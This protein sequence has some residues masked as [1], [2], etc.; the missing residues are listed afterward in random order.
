MEKDPKSPRQKE[1]LAILRTISHGYPRGHKQKQIERKLPKL[2]Q[3]AGLMDVIQRYHILMK[4]IIEEE[5]KKPKIMLPGLYREYPNKDDSAFFYPPNNYRPTPILRLKDLNLSKEQ[6]KQFDEDARDSAGSYI[7]GLI[8]INDGIAGFI[9]MQHQT[10][11][12]IPEAVIGLFVFAAEQIIEQETE[13]KDQEQLTYELKRIVAYEIDENEEEDQSENEIQSKYFT[14]GND[15]LSKN[16]SGTQLQATVNGEANPEINIAKISANTQPHNV[17]GSEGLKG[18]GCGMHLQEAT[19]ENR[20]PNHQ[21]IDNTGNE[22]NN[23]QVNENRTGDNNKTTQDPTM[24]A[25][26]N[27]KLNS[28]TMQILNLKRKDS[29]TQ[30]IQNKNQQI[31]IFHNQKASYSQSLYLTNQTKLKEKLQ[32]LNRRYNKLTN[33]KLEAEQ[34]CKNP[35]PISP[36]GVPKLEPISTLLTTSHPSRSGE[37]R[38]M[39]LQLLQTSPQSTPK[40]T[41]PVQDPR[42]RNKDSTQTTKQKQSP[43]PRLTSRISWTEDEREE[44][45]REGRDLENCET[46]KENREILDGNGD[47]IQQRFNLQ[48]KDNQR[49]NKLQRWLW[50]MK[51]RGTKEEAQEYKIIIEEQ[52][53]ENILIP[54]GKGQIKWYNP[55]FMIKKANGKL[56]KILNVK[57]SNEQVADFHF[58]MHDLNEVKQTIRLGDSGTSLDHS[59]AVRR[60]IVQKESQPYLAIEFQNYYYT[61]R[62]MLFGT[63]HSPIYFATAMELIIRE[64]RMKTEIRIINSVDDILLLLQN[65]KYLKNKT[66]QVI[67]TLKYFGFT[68]NTEKSE[69]EPNQTVIF[70]GCEWNLANATVTTKSKMDKDRNR[71]S[72]KINSEANM[73]TKLPKTVILRSFTLREHNGP[74]ES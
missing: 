23:E 12:S 39:Q 61:Y 1:T 8:N 54:I 50:I 37:K 69:T 36:K 24:N 66:Y 47:F 59:S 60:L 16:D 27:K 9:N 20:Y 49:I 21:A 2:H 35:Y 19:N 58:K 26:M 73:K 45:R 15:G 63:K 11:Q 31:Q 51:F 25:N 64:I 6:L 5:K 68:M 30:P 48:R 7:P 40:A 10:Y 3:I 41:K 71:D 65:K 62:V 22:N 38:Q 18:N 13:S 33:T 57:A 42:N 4:P 55:T 70:L 53:K 29:F 56:R 52:L 17:N 46:D 43:I 14:K 67:D 32:Y 74:S 72:S 34:A 44:E 28:K